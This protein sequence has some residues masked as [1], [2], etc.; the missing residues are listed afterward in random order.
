[1]ALLLPSVNKQ[2]FKLWIVD[3]ESL[4]QVGVECGLPLFATPKR[5]PCI[6]TV[7]RTGM[8]GFVGKQVFLVVRRGQEERSGEPIV[9][10]KEIDFLGLTDEKAV[11]IMQNHKSYVSG[12]VKRLRV[13]GGA[14][15]Q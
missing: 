6:R 4:F 12:Y 10:S 8:T 13:R 11:E 9:W 14:F 3:I 15:K 5:N 7:Y 1:V 2:Q